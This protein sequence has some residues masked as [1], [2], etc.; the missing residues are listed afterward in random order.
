MPAVSRAWTWLAKPR[1]RSVLAFLGAGL[2]AIVAAA[3][4]LYLHMTPP[5]PAASAPPSVIVQVQPAQAQAAPAAG[6]SPDV[7]AAKKLQESVNRLA[8]NE[9][10]AIDDI[11]RQ[12]EAANP[13]PQPAKA[14]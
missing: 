2:A 12:I 5:A 8:T 10:S 7:G 9:A 3:W 4:Q 11:S 6:L 1:N 13:P 14:R